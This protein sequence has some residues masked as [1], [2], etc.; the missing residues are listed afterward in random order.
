MGAPAAGPPDA[1]FLR[2]AIAGLGLIGGSIALAARRRWPGITIVGV[3]RPAVVAEADARHLV[4]RASINLGAMDEADLVILAAPVFA[5][6][7]LLSQLSRAIS[8]TAI[9]TDTGSTKRAIAAAA[10]GLPDRLIFA[11]G[12]PM[13]GGADG[14]LSAARAD[15]FDGRPWL[16]ATADI[17]AAAGKRL[18]AFVEGLGARPVAVDAE[19]HD[20]VLAYVSHLPQLAASALMDVVGAGVG[21]PGLAW[22][23]RG[24]AD[25]TR[26]A[27]S[28]A[29]IW[30]DIV[31]SNRDNV[32][33]ALDAL[34]A[35]LQALRGDLDSG[36]ELE[37]IF[38]SA[39]RWRA[40]LTVR[41]G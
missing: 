4:D 18:M 3:D 24:L 29:T 28:E 33:E 19:T 26:L 14:G 37:R 13:A 1:P 15:L 7:E 5:N 23:G 17:P 31:S 39:A 30:R 6:V 8:H 11:G 25:T 9:V 38:T 21:E 32:G 10:A 16:L 22:S 41:T 27:A 12:H 35:A 34:I 36:A 20:R 40:A 2:V